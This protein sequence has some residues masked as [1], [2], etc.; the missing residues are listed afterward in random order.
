M[1]EAQKHYNAILETG[2]LK[3]MF[4]HL[5]GDWDKDKKSFTKH[6]EEN[7]KILNLDSIDLDDEETDDYGDY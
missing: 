2:E 4:P 6:F 3:E 5:K 1:T 7:Q